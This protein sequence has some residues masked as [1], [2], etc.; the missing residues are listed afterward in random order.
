MELL[1]KIVTVGLVAALFLSAGCASRVSK[2]VSDELRDTKLQYEGSW[3][4]HR[5]KA[6]RKQTFGRERFNCPVDG[7]K[8]A[9]VVRSGVMEMNFRGKTHKTNVAQDGSFRME[10]PT[11][12]SYRRSRGA[13]ANK[14]EI[15]VI[16]QGSLAGD[17]PAGLYT[18]GT[19]RLNNQGCEA[20]TKFIKL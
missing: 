20:R 18:I 15:T 19:A 12:K 9:V 13:N 2:P 5:L 16:L 1:K 3:Q 4:V 11:D 6:P 8:F 17:N 7:F 14:S 10:I